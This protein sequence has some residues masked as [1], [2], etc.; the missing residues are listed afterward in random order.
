MGRYRP[1]N[2]PQPGFAAHIILAN[3]C[4]SGRPLAP[5]GTPVLAIVG[6]G[7]EVIKGSCKI[8]R[9]VKGSGSIVIPEAA[10]SVLDYLETEQAIEEFLSA[11]DLL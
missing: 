9:E 2:N 6:G 11:V 3:N 5:A 1:I 10:H 7:D 8:L 4:D